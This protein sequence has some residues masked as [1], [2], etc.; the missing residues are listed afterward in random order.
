MIQFFKQPKVVAELRQGPLGGYLEIFA[1]QLSAER[2][3]AEAARRQLRLIA[4][5]GWWM[6][7]NRLRVEE[8]S[9]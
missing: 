4:E 2:Y 8:L 6:K 3:G 5:F 1:C 9:S 7:K